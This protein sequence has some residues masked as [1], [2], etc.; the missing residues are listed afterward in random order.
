[1]SRVD[2]ENRKFN[3]E[4]NAFIVD[5][6]THPGLAAMKHELGQVL[7]TKDLLALVNWSSF[8]DLNKDQK[9][10]VESGNSA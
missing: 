5:Q 2:V 3:R 4:L 1:M 8:A 9:A 7:R 6:Q 10:L